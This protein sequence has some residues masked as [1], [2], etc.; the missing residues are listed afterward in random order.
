V[1]A[2]DLCTLQDVRI[3][4]EAPT[5]DTSRD[6]LIQSLITAASDAIMDEVDREFAP[7]TTA[8][9]RIKV[10]GYVV[11]LAPWDLRS[12]TTLTLHPETSSPQTLVAGTDYELLPV[13]AP[14]GTYS[15]LRLSSYLWLAG[16]TAY[17]M[18]HSLIDVNGAWGFATVPNVVNRACVLTVLSWIRRDISALGLSNEFDAAAAQPTAFGIPYEAR[19]LL[20]PFYR[21]DTMAF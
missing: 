21:L 1:A 3:A 11:S 19:R 16:D 9:R 7:A 5:S 2:Q 14:S 13:G 6:A 10:G 15:S 8:T 4:D 12:V 17:R 20:T 18:G